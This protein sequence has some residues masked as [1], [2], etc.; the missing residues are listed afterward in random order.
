MHYTIFSV[1]SN[2][3]M[4]SV[5]KVWSFL[6]TGEHNGAQGEDCKEVPVRHGGGGV[7]EARAGGVPAQDQRHHVRGRVQPVVDPGPRVP[8]F[9]HLYFRKDAATAF[10]REQHSEKVLP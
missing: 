2:S 8:Q 6:D 3:A 1:T 7:L 10:F 5:L 4:E 9:I